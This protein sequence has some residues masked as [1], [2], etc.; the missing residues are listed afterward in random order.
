[1]GSEYMMAMEY[2]DRILGKLN[3]QLILDS[4]YLNALTAGLLS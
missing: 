3:I 1:M 2:S 4:K